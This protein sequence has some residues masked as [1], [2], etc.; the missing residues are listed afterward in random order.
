MTV[1]RLMAGKTDSVS[2]IRSDVRVQDVI[3]RLESDDV[4]AL[5]VSNDHKTIL[6]DYLRWG[7]RPWLKAVWTKHSRS[8]IRR[9]DDPHRHFLRHWRADEQD[10]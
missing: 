9:L 7:Y 3:D 1:R 2:V 10:L 6:G 5:V 8:A 4:G